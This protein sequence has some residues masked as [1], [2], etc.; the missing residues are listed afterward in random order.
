MEFTLLWAAALGAAGLYGGLRVLAKVDRTV[1]V[2][3]LWD[4][5]LAAGLV[6]L[7]VGRLV[8]MI[9]GG[10]NPIANPGDFLL[11]RAGVDTVGAS[12]AAIGMAGWMARRNLTDQLDA[13]TAPAL[14]ALAGWHGGCLFRDACLGTPSNLPWAFSQAGSD[15][16]R[17]PVELYAAAGLLLGAAGLISLRKRFPRPLTLAGFGLAVA[18]AVRLST[19][20][21]RPA[22]DQGPVWWYAAAIVVG[23]GTATGAAV[24]SARSDPDDEVAFDQ[25]A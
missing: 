17:H 1:C 7:V 16:T 3:D 12:L 4:I 13:L 25:D 9:R 20:P 14:I 21:I 8:A 6:G 15:I 23:V 2:R 10:V 18:G 24:F 5:A 22:I 19:E 11:I